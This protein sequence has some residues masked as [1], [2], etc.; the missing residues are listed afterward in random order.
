MLFKRGF[1]IVEV[2]VVIV[3][4]SI[5][6]SVIFVGSQDSGRRSR[7]AERK[8]DLKTLQ[9]AVELYR[10]KY[11]RYPQGCR[12][13]TTAINQSNWSGHSGTYACASG[14]EYIIGLAPE[15]IPALPVDPKLNGA[16]SGYV[17]AVNND[18]TV[19]KIA[20]INTVESESVDYAHL[21]Y[22]CGTGDPSFLWHE[23]VSVPRT[24]ANRTGYVYNR[25]TGSNGY[26]HSSAQLQQCSQSTHYSNDY[27]VFGGYSDGDSGLDFE[28]SREFFSDIV[29]CK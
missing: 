2:M 15:F 13:A 20:A 27:A 9:N 6:A 28:R 14:N 7:D 4:I 12:G 17:Y 16:N 1:T 26:S 8:T 18:G 21:M 22:R 25:E 5:V 3:V 10:L 24:A 11:G 19:Y 23:C 29:R